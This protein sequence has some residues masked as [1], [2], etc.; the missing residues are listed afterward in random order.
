MS[1]THLWSVLQGWFDAQFFRVTQ[2]QLADRIGVQRSALSQWKNG[3]ARPTPTNLRKIAE[4]TGLDYDDLLDALMTDMG[5]R[6][7]EAGTDDVDPTLE[8]QAPVSGASGDD[9]SWRGKPLRRDDVDVAARTKPPGGT[10]KERLDAAQDAA[11]E[12]V[13]E[14]PDDLGEGSQDEPESRDA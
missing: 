1:T 9:A 6:T 7:R 14:A 11:G 12:A 2:A 3:Q 10:M 13:D 8:T 4:V 5:Y